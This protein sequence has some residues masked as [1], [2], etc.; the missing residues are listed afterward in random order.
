LQLCVDYRAL[1]KLTIKN[2]YPLSLIE[3]F[4]DRFSNAK[5]FTKFDVRGGFNRLRMGAGEEWKTAFRCRY[6]S[7]E[8][9]MMFFDLCNAPGTFQYYMNDTFRDFLDEILVVYLD[10]LLIYSKML[11]EHKQ[12]V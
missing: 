12:Y 11:K 2:H 8:Y 5:F 7:F 1:N 3:E 6:G 9:I 10:D 4:L